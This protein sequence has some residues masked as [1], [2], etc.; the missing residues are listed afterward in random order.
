MIFDVISMKRTKIKMAIMLFSLVFFVLAA[1][2]D[3]YFESFPYSKTILLISI[4]LF[5]L[6]VFTPVM[7][8]GDKEIGKLELA[9]SFICFPNEREEMKKINLSEIESCELKYGGFKGEPK[10][11]IKGFVFESGIN[12]LKIKTDKQEFKIAFLS[13]TSKDEDKLTDYIKILKANNIDCKTLLY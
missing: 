6:V 7:L 11:T 9:N 4:I 1:I 2:L 10:L 13:Y 5:V 8:L 3:I 12:Y